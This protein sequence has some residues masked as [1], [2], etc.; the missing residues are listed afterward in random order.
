[1][2]VLTKFKTY[3]LLIKGSQTKS[4]ILKCLR[5]KADQ[6]RHMKM[7]YTMLVAC[8]YGAYKG[9]HSESSDTHPSHS[10]TIYCIRVTEREGFQSDKQHRILHM[11]GRE[12]TLKSCINFRRFSFSCRMWPECK[13]LLDTF[14]TRQ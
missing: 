5:R 3:E 4:E 6:R 9:G 13:I 8:L 10:A 2:C 1:M 11:P 12:A 14:H 7:I